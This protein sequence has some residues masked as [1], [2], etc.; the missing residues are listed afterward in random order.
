MDTYLITGGA[1]FIG[2]NFIRYLLE[3]DPTVQIINIDKLTYAGS[4][5]NLNFIS[6]Q[7]KYI[8]VRDDICD[9]ERVM[10]LFESY[11]PAYIIN[12]AAE[13][14]VDRSIENNEPF[15][16]TNVLGTQILLQ[17]ALKYNVK[18]FI[19]ISTDEGQEICR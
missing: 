17:S 11:Q 3:K 16:R 5:N 10:D 7:F 6:K 15:V 19:Q 2:S 8:F 14:H 4:L 18:K 12:F 13:S 9:K 1:G